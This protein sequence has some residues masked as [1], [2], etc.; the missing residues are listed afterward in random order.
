[1]S[2]VTVIETN[3]NENNTTESGRVLEV[4]SAKKSRKNLKTTITGLFNGSEG[5]E[6]KGKVQ[7]Q[8]TTSTTTAALQT[9]RCMVFELLEGVGEFSKGV[10]KVIIKASYFCWYCRMYHVTQ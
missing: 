7:R 1:M 10:L 3:V 4:K 9:T 8:A 6:D 2:G 5:L